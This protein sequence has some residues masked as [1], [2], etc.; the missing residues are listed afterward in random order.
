M[1]NILSR[2]NRPCIKDPYSY[3]QESNYKKIIEW[4]KNLIEMKKA[5]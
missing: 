4:L 5:R 3:C 1:K 2:K